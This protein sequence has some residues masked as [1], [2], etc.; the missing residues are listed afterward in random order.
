M[1]AVFAP[2]PE[3]PHQIALV[4]R[5]DFLASAPKSSGLTVDCAVDC[6]GHQQDFVGLGGSRFD[7]CQADARYLMLSRGMLGASRKGRDR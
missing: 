7:L 2:P 3:K 6:E 5:F 4:S 1:R